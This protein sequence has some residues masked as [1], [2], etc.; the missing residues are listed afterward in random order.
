MDRKLLWATLRW[1]M[2]APA[3]RDNL[4]RAVAELSQRA[5]LG[6]VDIRREARSSPSRTRLRVS[7][8]L[9]PTLVE[10]VDLVRDGEPLGRRA[11]H[12][13]WRKLRAAGQQTALVEGRQYHPYLQRLDRRALQAYFRGL[14]H[15]DVS[16]VAEAATLGDLTRVTYRIRTGPRFKLR[17]Q[18]VAGHTFPPKELKGLLGG[19]R[20]ARGEPP[21]PRLL[22]ARA[23]ALRAWLCRRGYSDA[24]VGP[25]V[26][27]HGDGL[28][29]VLYWAVPGQRRT[30][31]ELHMV[32][33]AE[34]AVPVEA[35]GL[36]V[37]T[38]L[39]RD[40][41][42][43]A[44]RN[45]VKAFADAGFPAAQVMARV[46]PTLSRQPG[47]AEPVRVELRVTPGEP[48]I[49]HR[50][51]FDGA[52]V[53]HEDVLRQLLEIQEGDRA[54]QSAIDASVQ[55]LLRTG[56]F[57]TVRAR[58]IRSSDLK[59]HY[60]R[61]VLR[62]RGL[63]SVDPVDRELTLHNM[64]V[65]VLPGSVAEAV[66]DVTLRGRGQSVVLTGRPEYVSFKLLDPFLLPWVLAWT[67]VGWAEY[68]YASLTEYSGFVRLGVGYRAW[69]NRFVL[70]PDLSWESTVADA[71]DSY[72]ALPVVTDD[73]HHLAVGLR[74]SLDLGLLNAERIF[75]L[76]LRL[77]GR[78]AGTW[79]SP[80]DSSDDR[81]TLAQASVQAA[82]PLY[83]NGRD[84]HWVLELA[85]TTAHL[86][87]ED[88]AA[89]PAHRRLAPRARGYTATAT[90]LTH[91]VDTDELRLGGLRSYAASGSLRVPL[92]WRRNALLPFV[93]VAALG[94]EQSSATAN[95]FLAAGLRLDF[96]LFNERLEGYV[97]FAYPLDGDAASDY[98]DASVGGSF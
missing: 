58:L 37:G 64:N 46:T 14:G 27:R 40:D 62:E 9:L 85:A 98:L 73:S 97:H 48:A 39:C 82:L 55:N 33:D 94:D 12:Q 38:P 54:R 76:G 52:R 51:W 23:E 65:F 72:A 3:S 34:V 44:H 60:L 1:L 84:Q 18:R 43:R 30:I 70:V 7:F 31:A 15:V 5:G 57:R 75:Y 53:T 32:Q 95:V 50:I 89:L 16:V 63:V 20:P 74:S 2:N 78:V 69:A 22:N 59:R 11:G 36:T 81:W 25:T 35:T 6:Q 71:P 49:V 80:G 91:A 13:L 28:A 24:L 88:P 47:Q 41:L 17:R 90:R 87:P 56:L 29:D 19:K 86:F 4:L 96:S 42:T 68:A 61:F 92:P 66:D 77:N 26:T 10:R 93:D 79:L 21:S 67:E 45:L 83:R 8:T